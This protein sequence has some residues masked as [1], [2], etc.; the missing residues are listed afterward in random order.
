MSSRIGGSL[1]SKVG[2]GGP[3][4]YLLGSGAQRFSSGPASIEIIGSAFGAAATRGTRICILDGAFYNRSELPD[5]RNDAAR[6]LTLLERLPLEAALAR[7]NGDFAIA[8]W[9]G[10]TLHLIRD[11]FGVRPLYHAAAHGMF[12]FA[13]RP[14]TLLAAAAIPP[15]PNPQFLARFAGSHY[16]TI[17]NEPT[18]SPYRAISQLPAGMRLAVKPGGEPALFRWWRIED[19]PDMEGSEAELSERYGAL[20]RD[21]VAT[22][23]AAAKRPAFTLSGGM[24]S[25]SVLACAVATAAASL[26]AYS[27]VYDDKTFDESDEIR[28][29]LD[30]HARPWIPVRSGNHIDILSE[31]R[32]AVADHDE[33]I[34]TATWLAHRHL[35]REVAARGHDA[36]FGG[37]GG[38]EL[39]AGEFEYFAMHFADLRARGRVAELD[40]EIDAWAR[41]HDHPIWRKDRAKAESDMARLTDPLVPGRVRADRARIEKYAHTLV[42][43]LQPLAV[44]EPE[45]EHPFSSYLKNR[46]WQDLSRETAPCCLRAED[47][48]GAAAGV[49]QID[50]FFDHRLI[51]FM[52]AVPGT[53]KIRDGVTKRLLRNAMKGLLPE[54]T[55]SRVKKTGWNAPA[56]VWFGGPGLDRVRDLV[57]SRR[58]RERGVY[59]PR[60]V[61]VVLD[62]HAAILASGAQKE[63]H[64]MF[65]WQ[66]VNVEFWLDGVSSGQA[67]ASADRRDGKDEA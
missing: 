23:F 31:I 13:S 46:T 9:D 55:R 50:P 35:M 61:S 60:A 5:E 62:E 54:E 51:E 59:D 19:R 6:F 26:P 7:L 17:D 39:N 1:L 53:M 41:N 45:M 40:L 20:L 11:R 43:D 33:P 28:P 63:T 18:E 52:F 47:R 29:M 24:D 22:R 27:S 32:D 4:K 38:D 48:H 3:D 14:G 21:A 2:S 16:R 10:D 25:S 15:A 64:M 66:L 37:L 67:A 58:F 30:R 56:H 34:A 36:V 44:A 57:A 8:L 12:H 49:R 65:L 42:P